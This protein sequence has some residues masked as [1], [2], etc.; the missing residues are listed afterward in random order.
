M[1]AGGSRVGMAGKRNVCFYPARRAAQ[2]RER[3]P[4]L[5]KALLPY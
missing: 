5:I 2:G 3:S 4:T 1:I